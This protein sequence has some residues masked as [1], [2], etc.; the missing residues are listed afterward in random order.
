MTDN[1][2]PVDISEIVE[3]I[4]VRF[5]A[6]APYPI[7]PH[8]ENGWLYFGGTLFPFAQNYCDLGSGMKA[9]LDVSVKAL[10]E[11]QDEISRELQQPWPGEH[12]QP[13][14]AGA[15]DNQLLYLWFGSQQDPV[16]ALA[17]IELSR[18]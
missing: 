7:E 16:L 18:G 11:L 17:P 8:A 2:S 5:R 14:P 12:E 3:Q 10:S 9:L 15:I 13:M 1:G 4:A 6:A